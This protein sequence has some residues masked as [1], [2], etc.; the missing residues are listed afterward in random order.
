VASPRTLA[1]I[2]AIAW[3]LIYGGLF[4][5]IL[6]IASHDET[7]IGGWSLSVIGVAATVAGIVLILVRARLRDDD[8]PPS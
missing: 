2:D 7:V 6:G 4:S 3:I 8:R 5:L 1:R